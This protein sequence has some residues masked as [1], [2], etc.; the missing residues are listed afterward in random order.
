MAYVWVIYRLCMVYPALW[1]E[2]VT[3]MI[4]MKVVKSIRNN[5]REVRE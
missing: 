2:C 3:V 1:Y 4:R 5:S